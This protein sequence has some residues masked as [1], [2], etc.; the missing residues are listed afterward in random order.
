MIMISL[1]A[2]FLFGIYISLTI[3][4]YILHESI[5]DLE[6]S[7]VRIVEFI[8]ESKEADPDYQSAMREVEEFLGN[9]EEKKRI[10]G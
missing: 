4:R 3:M 9:I 6:K 1:F 5:D 10:N 7:K 8:E 2:V